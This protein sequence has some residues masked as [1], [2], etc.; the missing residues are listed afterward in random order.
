[1]VNNSLLKNE[2]IGK[3]FGKVEIATII[4]KLEGKK[5]K[6]TEKNYLYRSIRPKLIAASL[7]EES[8]I[9]K[10]INKSK[11]DDVDMIEYNLALYGYLMFWLKK[12]K[13]EKIGIE[14]LIA[15]ILVKHP[16]ARYIEAIPIII[17]KNKVDKFKILEIAIR[18]GLKNKIGYL[19]ETAM[20]LKP[21]AYL[22]DILSYL[23][24]NKDEEELFLVEG[25][26]DFLSRTSPKRVKKW[27][28]LGR[29]F[30]E[31]FIKN[32]RMYL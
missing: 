1:M 5:L 9:L 21:L 24:K 15:K 30:D 16:N 2:V 20:M 18:H 29:F 12:I 7:L 6:Q 19:I 26:Y 10:E 4:R 27:N 32:A 3:I 28:L 31:D 8:G 22:N 13:S 23:E 14:E 11:K 25:D 17:I